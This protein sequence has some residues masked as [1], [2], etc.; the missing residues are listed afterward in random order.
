MELNTIPKTGDYGTG[1]DRHNDNYQKIGLKL[2]T[3][4]NMSFNEKGYFETLSALETKYPVPH[5]GWQAYVKDAGSSTGYYVAN[6]NS[7]GAWVVTSAEAP[8][9]GVD[10]NGYALTGGS[11]KTIKDVEDEIVQLAGDTQR[12]TEWIDRSDSIE[13]LD[14][15]NTDILKAWTDKDG[16]VVAYIDG[17]GRFKAIHLDNEDLDSIK[18]ENEYAK[19]IETLDWKEAGILKAWTDQNGRIVAYIDR[20]GVFNAPHLSTLR[21]KKQSRDG[22][23]VA[24]WEDETGKIFLYVD[25]NGVVH[26]PQ[27]ANV[28]SDEKINLLQKEVLAANTAIS[29][30]L[31]IQSEET[32]QRNENIIFSEKGNYT[33]I[34]SGQKSFMPGFVLCE[35]DGLDNR[36]PGNNTNPIWAGGFYSVLFP[37]AASLG[38]PI[39]IA[40]EGQRV[41]ALEGQLNLTG[42]II[43]DLQKKYNWEVVCHTMTARFGKCHK[44]QSL[45]E[46]NTIPGHPTAGTNPTNNDGRYVFVEPE[47]KN[48]YWDTDQSWKEV[49]AEYIQ[50]FLTDYVTG[51]NIADNPTFPLHYQLK[52][53]KEIMKFLGFGDITI[54]TPTNSV[55]SSRII[56]YA[57]NLFEFITSVLGYGTDNGKRIVP[58]LG[59][60]IPRY[61][62]DYPSQTDPVTDYDIDELNTWKND[63]D[64]AIAEGALMLF[65]MHSYRPSWKNY[66]EGQ[67]VSEGGTYPDAWVYPAQMPADMDSDP[68]LYLQPDPATGLTDWKDWFPCPGTRLR[69]LWDFVKYI[70]STGK[71]IE[72]SS[73]E[74]HSRKNIIEYGILN[75]GWSSHSRPFDD[76]NP[77][78]YV[79]GCDGT[80]LYNSK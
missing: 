6:V 9:V 70:Q 67:L 7:S 54:Y 18:Q 62:I 71:N 75:S 66:K 25:K 5:P 74:L 63:V 69:Q 80:I 44:V 37:V 77:N 49:P 3:L 60:I 52:H 43:Q 32:R 1:V 13:I 29:S 12:T 4:E 21:E 41:G 38:I 8:S 23:N 61:G 50:P 19:S 72:I 11:E 35:D 40:V 26:I 79:M 30:I 42:K 33:I 2:E 39:T 53:Y 14:E 10:L 31:R 59:T 36:I 46:A 48:Y 24:V 27:L 16:R 76:P 58:P 17:A 20:D 34:P 28:G 45:S 65:Y 51:D 68:D 57:K 64:A 73:K 55:T 56:N 22:E 47:H 78:Y 15:K